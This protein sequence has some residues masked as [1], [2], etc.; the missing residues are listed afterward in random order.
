[1]SFAISLCEPE[2]K[3]DVDRSSEP[4]VKCIGIVLYDDFSLSGTGTFVEAL[5]IANEL[6]RSAEGWRLKYRVCFVSALGGPVTSSSSICVLTERLGGQRFG[7]FD[8]LYVAG[9]PG[10]TR[11][12]ADNGLIE[13]LKIT[14]SRD[15]AI[16][17]LGNGH[18]LLTAAGF[19]CDNTTSIERDI[20]TW[21]HHNQPTTERGDA[22]VYSL[23]LVNRDLGY[24]IAASVAERLAF[25][26]DQQVRSILSRPGTPT[27]AEKTLESARWLERNCGN[28]VSVVDAAR[29]AAM[30]ERN[31][32]RLFK[33]E[34]GL[35][36]SQ[37]LLRARLQLCCDLLTT[38]ELPIDKIARRTG[39]SNGE[40]MA[41]IFR[42]QFSMSPTEF[43]ARKRD[44]STAQL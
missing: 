2:H 43:R 14:Y 41:K 38:S 32:W 10:A 37:Y 15:S 36:P 31:F 18:E 25:S 6:Q 20:S 7:A 21:P 27:A 4:V 16:S 24:D 39:L 42:K 17:A 1:M 13:L 30:S 23:A 26:D 19:Q 40:R 9:G 11:A 44:K 22:L 12:S 5:H 3:L 28:P 8:A 29:I 35:T 33:R 34:M